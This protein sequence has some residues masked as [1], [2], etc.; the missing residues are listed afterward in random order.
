M[1]T[2]AQDQQEGANANYWMQSNNIHGCSVGKL[3]SGATAAII[4]AS[5][6]EV[7]AQ[8]K[9]SAGHEHGPHL[10]MTRQALQPRLALVL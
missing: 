1:R 7:T 3:D 5:Q 4:P 6:Q 9:R 10:Q 8:I 2:H